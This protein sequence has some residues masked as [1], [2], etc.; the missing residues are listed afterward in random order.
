MAY[1]EETLIKQDI[2]DMNYWKTVADVLKC[3]LVGWTCQDE[4]T[5]QRNGYIVHVP[6]WLAELVLELDKGS[7]P[8]SGWRS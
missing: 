7:D 1:R 4:A 8:Y 3:E 2:Q 6:R 5:M